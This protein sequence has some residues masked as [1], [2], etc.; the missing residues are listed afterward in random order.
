LDAEAAEVAYLTAAYTGREASL[1][2]ETA[3]MSQH[4]W[5]DPSV[6]ST[7]ANGVTP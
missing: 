5:A 6:L 4:R 2:T 7:G 3:A 1:V